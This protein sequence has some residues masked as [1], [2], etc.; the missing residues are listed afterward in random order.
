MK[1]SMQQK[2]RIDEL[3]LDVQ[4]QGAELM[5]KDCAMQE[6]V[7]FH[8]SE[9]EIVHAKLHDR[10]ART[11][12]LIVEVEELR[13]QLTLSKALKEREMRSTASLVERDAEWESRHGCL[14]QHYDTLESHLRDEN[15]RL[16]T[17]QEKL[18]DTE[19]QLKAEE[20]GSYGA[21]HDSGLWSIS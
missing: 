15:T 16:L 19:E 3:L 6:S 10:N 20:R 18:E 11:D 8:Q 4:R 12:L 9:M 7:D 2:T 14:A 1:L 21:K 13:A 5:E 17:L